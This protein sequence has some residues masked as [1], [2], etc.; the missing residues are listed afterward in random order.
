MVEFF[1][2]DATMPTITLT[3]AAVIT[4][5]ALT[6]ALHQKKLP[7]HLAELRNPSKSALERLAAI[8]KTPTN[9]GIQPIA[10]PAPPPRWKQHQ[11]QDE[12][13]RLTPPESCPN[14]SV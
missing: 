8:Y 4:A 5:D 3:E 7:I 9:L 6:A 13:G 14:H 2:K 1:P 12:H 11:W 10:N